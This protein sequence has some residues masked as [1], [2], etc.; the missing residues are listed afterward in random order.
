M[1]QGDDMLIERVL[2][3]APVTGGRDRR[4]LSCDGVLDLKLTTPPE[5]GGSNG[6]GINPEQLFAASY[7]A[8]FLAMMK[9]VAARD[10]IALPVGAAVEATVGIG[11]TPQGFGIEVELRISLPGLPRV[12]ADSL[13]EK[14]HQACPYPNATRGK[15]AVRLV[16]ARAGR[17]AI[18]RACRHLNGPWKDRCPCRESDQRILAPN[19]VPA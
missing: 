9:S 2:Y 3:R 11:P 10:S 6:Q 1:R 18:S 14:S 8:S 17:L 15:V 16:L 12:E 5:L 7:A 4:A 19:S 13:V